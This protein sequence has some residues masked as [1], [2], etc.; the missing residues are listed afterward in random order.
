MPVVYCLCVATA[1]VCRLR[2]AGL[3][4]EEKETFVKSRGRPRLEPW[5]LTCMGLTQ[6]AP[7]SRQSVPRPSLPNGNAA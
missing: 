1:A 7:E 5:N 4:E 3:H 2:A 6:F